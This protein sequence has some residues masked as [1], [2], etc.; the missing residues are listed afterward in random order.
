[1]LEGNDLYPQN[2][3]Y[4]L[5]FVPFCRDSE[6]HFFS[7]LY[8]LF[9]E[10]LPQHRDYKTAVIPEKRETMKVS[11]NIAKSLTAAVGNVLGSS[12]LGFHSS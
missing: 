9:I 5:V 4:C 10:K 2:D 6:M 8:R 3:T 12:A 7:C 1:M 11:S